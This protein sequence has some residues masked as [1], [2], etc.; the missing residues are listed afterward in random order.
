MLQEK[1]V[2]LGLFEIQKAYK[3][4]RDN[5]DS[6]K[7]T[8]EFALLV[9]NNV[10]M[11]G[12]PFNQIEEGLYNE[13]NDAQYVDY[14]QRMKKLVMQYIDRDEQGNPKFDENQ[15]PKITEMAVEYQKA[16]DALDAQ[17]T[18]LNDRMMKKDENNYNFLKQKVK[19]KIIGMDIADIPDGIPP[20]IVGIITKPAV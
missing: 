1:Q 3:Y 5:L 15:Q 19:V 10:I 16:A 17:F 20:S 2:E 8:A 6:E 4:F 11:L 12:Q 18:D 14:C 9:Y 13:Q 7:F